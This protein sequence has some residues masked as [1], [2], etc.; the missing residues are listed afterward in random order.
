MFGFESMYQLKSRGPDSREEQK[1]HDVCSS[2]RRW[3]L[4]SLQRRVDNHV[5]K[6]VILRK[7]VGGDKLGLWLFLYVEQLG[8]RGS[9]QVRHLEQSPCRKPSE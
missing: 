4:N 7:K 6:Q 5:Q 1:H 9:S 8:W 2:P 3:K